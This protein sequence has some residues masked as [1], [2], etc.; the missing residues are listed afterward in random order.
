MPRDGGDGKGFDARVLALLSS[1][2]VNISLWSVFTPSSLIGI[3][4]PYPKTL[5]K[6]KPLEKLRERLTNG[7]FVSV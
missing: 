7:L 1:E 3:Y 5:P 6:I 2:T 4:L